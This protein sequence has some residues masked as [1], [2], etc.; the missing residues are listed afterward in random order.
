VNYAA[1][2]IDLETGQTLRRFWTTDQA[3]DALHLFEWASGHP[4]VVMIG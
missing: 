1:S 3:R 4:C 2:I